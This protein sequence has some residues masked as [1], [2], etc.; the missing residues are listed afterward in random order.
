MTLEERS[1]QYSPSSCLPDRDLMPFIAAYRTQSAKAW[2][3]LENSSTVRTTSIAYGDLPSQTVDLAVPITDDAGPL[4]VYLHG[5]YWQELSKDDSTFA[6]LDCINQ[7]WAF[8]A[9]DY[10]LAP[11]ATIPEIIDECDRAVQRLID[12][13]GDLG[14]KHRAIV[15]A[16]SSA[17][18]HL[19]AMV[20]LRRIGS[21]API[22]GVVLVSGIYELQPLVDTY[23]ADPLD[24]DPAVVDEISPLR[25]DLAGFPPAVVAYG[26]N[27]TSEFKAQSDAFARRLDGS[28]T[29]VIYLEIEG[30]NHFDVI[31]DLAKPGTALGAAVTSLILGAQA[32]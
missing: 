4:I 17:G 16:G 31:L 19:A 13:A 28:G 10:T 18:A 22:A 6:A 7:G 21:D 25:A 3:E 1:D 27:E 30:R 20:A 23:I 32:S 14:L 12:D 2:A 11:A 5:G 26:D 29:S 9:I 15:L 24:L 8:A